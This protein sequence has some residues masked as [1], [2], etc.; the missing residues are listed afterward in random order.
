MP[1]VS[2]FTTIVGDTNIRI[3]DGSHETGFTRTFNT[4]G[5]HP[6]GNA[7]IS[8][9]VKGLTV[10]TEHPDVFV[11]DVKVGDLFNN[12]GGLVNQWQ[13]QSVSLGGN[14]LNDGNNVIRIVP[15]TYA[16]GGSDNFDDFYIRNVVCHYQQI[17]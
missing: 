5:R 10:T 17:V 1:L 15:A 4:G 14:Q 12:R 8:F 9:M 11:N 16:G 2:D 6:M 7:F 3:G 13:T